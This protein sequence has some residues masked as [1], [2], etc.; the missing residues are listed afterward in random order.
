MN[1]IYY[2]GKVIRKCKNLKHEPNRDYKIVF[3]LYKQ[4]AESI[5]VPSTKYEVQETPY[6]LPA[7]PARKQNKSI[8]K[9]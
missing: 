1:D 9:L 8:Y 4:R 2:T 7:P 3:V 6:K 5:I